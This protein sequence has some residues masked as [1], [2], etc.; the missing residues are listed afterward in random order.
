MPPGTKL[1]S[2]TIAASAEVDEGGSAG[3]ED[4]E[5]HELDEQLEK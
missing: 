1:G 2:K 5:L 4:P 3:D